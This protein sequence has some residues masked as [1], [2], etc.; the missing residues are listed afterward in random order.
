VSTN[1]PEP[2]A[3]IGRIPAPVVVGLVPALVA[4]AVSANMLLNGFVYDDALVFGQL[5]GGWESWREFALPSGSLAYAVHA[6]DHWLWGDWAPGFRLTNLILHAIASF[7]T[8]YAAWLVTGSK[9]IASICGLLFAVHPVHVEAVA[10]FANRD[11][12]LAMIFICLSLAL[13][14]DPGR[15]RSRYAGSLACVTLAFAAD[16]VT[17]AGVVPMLFIGDLLVRHDARSLRDRLKAAALRSAP[18]WLLTAGAVYGLA[19]DLSSYFESSSIFRETEGIAR[20]YTEVL[21]T[22]AA[23]VPELFRLLFFP[24]TLSADHPTRVQS[25]FADTPAL[26]GIVLLVVWVAAL[27]ALRRRAPLATFAMTWVVVTDLPRSNIIPF[28]NYFVAERF[29][30]VP[31]FGACLLIALAFD[32][33]FA[34]ALRK[35]LPALKWSLVAVLGLCTLAAANRSVQRNADWRSSES[36]ATSALVSGMDTWRMRRM[37]A[38]VNSQQGNFA[39]ASFNLRRAVELAPMFPELQIELATALLYEGGMIEAAEQIDLVNARSPSGS[40]AAASSQNLGVA[41]ALEGFPEAAVEQYHRALELEPDYVD[42][43]HNLAVALASQGELLEAIRHYRRALELQPERADAHHNLGIALAAQGQREEAI[44][45]YRQALERMP[46]RAG[47]HH[48]LAIALALQHRTEEAIGHYRRAIEQ[49]P[50]N[51][52]AH[53]NL[54]VALAARGELEEAIQHYREALELD[55][56]RLDAKHNLG[57]TLALQAGRSAGSPEPAAAIGETQ[58]ESPDAAPAH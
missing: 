19:G 17:A 5:G 29:L 3:G 33:A 32:A 36:L 54:A 39:Q 37:L 15:K 57:I 41:L 49:E 28:T 7:L 13:W 42:A 44:R 26:I 25:S 22:S 6:G 4:A 30:Y 52:D 23:A 55:P 34:G 18:L 50:R 12:I 35:R 47:V 51:A 10:S 58:A 46:G 45:H 20:S 56:E 53:H 9:R 14:L 48:A 8:A 38:Q 2:A 31:S 27:L 24:V 1:Q 21:A 43:H 11:Q 16:A 40:W